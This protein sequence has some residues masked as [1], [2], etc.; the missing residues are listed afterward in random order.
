MSNFVLEALPGT[1]L[2]GVAINEGQGSV[3]EIPPSSPLLAAM[4]EEVWTEIM[5]F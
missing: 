3:G 5:L 1:G 4:P 2:P